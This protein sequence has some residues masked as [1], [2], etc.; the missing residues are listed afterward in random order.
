MSGDA[1][2]HEM[3]S[4]AM[5]PL[6]LLEALM[7]TSSKAL[8]LYVALHRWTNGADRTC[9]PS[10]KTLAEYLGVGT[11]TIDR[12]STDL[13]DIGALT[14]TRRY[15]PDGD[16]T[17]NLYTLRVVK[18]PL[19]INGETP[20]PTDAA[21]PLPT[22]GSLTKPISK[23]TQMEGSSS[24]VARRL[25]IPDRFD[26]FWSTYGNLAGT[27]RRKAIECWQ[28]AMKRGDDPDDIIEGLQAWVVYWRTPGASKAMYAQ[29]FL[30]QQKWAT[31][32]PPIMNEVGRKTAST[33]A[34]IARLRAVPDDLDIFALDSASI[35][36]VESGS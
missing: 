10:R 33:R 25:P 27:G 34:A 4:F 29:G 3:G 14:V 28:A 18:P 12:W 9:Y 21:T 5:V 16:P 17:S 19:P 13:Q 8:P 32:P 30:N 20:L 6:W 35:R 26:E 1:V 22:D 15:T 2:T 31:P 11:S 24:A 7:E 36:E 23:Q